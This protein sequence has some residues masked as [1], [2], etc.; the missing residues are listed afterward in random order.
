MGLD[1]FMLSSAIVNPAV[2]IMSAS[3]GFC[4]AIAGSL[5]LVGMDRIAG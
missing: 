2:T 5:S 3:F 4:K 1:K